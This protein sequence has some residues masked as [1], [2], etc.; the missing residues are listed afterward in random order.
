[1]VY[2]THTA[3]S[4]YP[5]KACWTVCYMTPLRHCFTRPSPIAGHGIRLPA[6][7][8]STTAPPGA[9][10]RLH[11]TAHTCLPTRTKFPQHRANLY[12]VDLLPSRGPT[13]LWTV[14]RSA[15]HLH[16]TF[17]LFSKT[18][19][20]LS[21]P[22][23]TPLAPVSQQY[24]LTRAA[25]C[26][27]FPTAPPTAAVAAARGTRFSCASGRTPDGQNAVCDGGCSG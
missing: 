16:F 19:V 6:P 7:T 13:V 1:M 22:P 15:L 25:T 4:A 10:A 2:H 8:A 21:T 24:R 18:V 9:R 23:L 27:R 11:T 12:R 3:P 17:L 5:Y 14:W 20:V 26:R